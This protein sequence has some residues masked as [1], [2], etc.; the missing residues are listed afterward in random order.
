[1]A[2]KRSNPLPMSG[3]LFVSNPGRKS[4]SKRTPKAKKPSVA[5]RI[6]AKL[7]NRS[8]MKI[9][10]NRKRKNGLALRANG[11]AIRA[12]RRRTHAKRAHKRKN[13]LAVRMNRRSTKRQRMNRRRNGLAVRMNGL[14]VRMN[15]RRMNRRRNKGAEK[16][17]GG[18]FLAAIT[19]PV[20]GIVSKIP[21]FG[22]TLGAAVM[23]LALG[24]A[25]GAVHVYALR[26]AGHYL[27]AAV[28]PFGYTI[29]GLVVKGVLAVVPVGSAAMR[30]SIGDAAVVVGGALDTIRYLKG[31]SDFSDGMMY[32]IGSYG[33]GA[34]R[35]PFDG[36]E[37]AIQTA[38]TD[39][40]SGDA[41]V[42]G[43]DLDNEEVAAA[44]GGP[45]AWA[46]RFPFARR[47]VI[48]HGNVSQHAGQPGHRWGWLF[49]LVGPENVAKIAAMP[50]EKRRAYIQ[51]L[52]Q[53]ALALMQGNA[54]P[55]GPFSAPAK[56][57]G[58]FSAPSV[59]LGPFS[60]PSVALGPFSSPAT[61]LGPFSAPSVP[62]AGDYGAALYAGGPF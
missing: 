60:A 6:I 35:L 19:K 10:R 59:A 54:V 22:K 25:V 4:S 62:F 39:A 15:K 31:Q 7:N 2:F 24:A 52:R 53:H 14:A 36:D 13:G 51:A 28:K 16:G 21:V 32:E 30:K 11:L 9:K 41:A 61:A 27:P 46:A 43:D 17:T 58:P 57:L 1:V 38:Y 50:V 26:F 47:T 18:N 49:R 55:L 33:E 23:P 34:Y 45:R 20:S 5:A 56:A 42:S 8:T 44:L 12:N 48:V 37:Q 29:G 3:A 40:K